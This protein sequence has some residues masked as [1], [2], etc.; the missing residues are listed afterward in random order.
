MKANVSILPPGYVGLPIP[1]ESIIRRSECCSSR[2]TQRQVQGE[3]CIPGP[4]SYNTTI[5]VPKNTSPAS[6]AQSESLR[7]SL[8]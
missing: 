3:V 6:A 2:A 7:D 1:S 4:S 5:N 8:L